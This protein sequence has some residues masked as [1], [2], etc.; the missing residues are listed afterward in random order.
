MIS[1]TRSLRA[2][3][4][5]LLL[6][7]G[8]PRESIYVNKPIDS[9]TVPGAEGT[10]TLTNNHSLLVSMLKAGVVTVRDGTVTTDY[11]V[12]DGFVFFNNPKDGSGCCTAEISGI[13]V[14]PTSALDKERALQMIAELNASPKDTEWAKVK[15]Q[16]G[17]NLLNQVAKAATTH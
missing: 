2:P 1:L 17:T 15:A 8:S 10:F 14:V 11:F 7:L 3:T 4:N 16:L 9:V 5:R 13:E 12:S 6:T